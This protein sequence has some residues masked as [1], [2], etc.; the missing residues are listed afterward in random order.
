MS[1]WCGAAGRCLTSRR[2]PAKLVRRPV[3]WG[4]TK[5]SNSAA[6]SDGGADE[7]VK[8]PF[9]VVKVVDALRVP[10]DAQTELPVLTFYG[11]HNAVGGAAGGDLEVFALKSGVH[12]LM[13]TGVHPEVLFAEKLPDEGVFF[14]FHK[15]IGVGAVFLFGVYV[16]VAVADGKVIQVLNELAAGTDAELLTAQTD[17]QKGNVTCQNCFD[18]SKV[19]FGNIFPEHGVVAFDGFFPE[20]AGRDI[21]TAD[22][23]HGVHMLQIAQRLLNSEKSRESQGETAVVVDCLTVGLGMRINGVDPDRSRDPCHADN[24]TLHFHMFHAL[25]MALAISSWMG[26]RGWVPSRETTHSL[27]GA[28]PWSS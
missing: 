3:D 13:V 26:A 6:V 4:G 27:K 28:L 7:S 5:H 22:E 18:Q 10:L 2:S 12:R 14:G 17:P 15:V 9:P 11:L 16:A 1:V 23:D 21:G 25:T 8:D 20:K 19:C 24:R